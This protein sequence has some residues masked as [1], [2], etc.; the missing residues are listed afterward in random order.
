MRFVC[1]WDED[2]AGH[3][4]LFD[5]LRELWQERLGDAVALQELLQSCSPPESMNR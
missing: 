5:Q 2:P 3:V 4:W 1:F